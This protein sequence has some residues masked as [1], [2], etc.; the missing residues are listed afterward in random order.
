MSATAASGLK[1]TVADVLGPF[2]KPGAP[3]R[4]NGSLTER[5][6]VD[7]SNGQPTRLTIAGKVQDEDGNA[8][9]GA[10]LDVWQAGPPDERGLGS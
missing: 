8:M 4:A 6:G 3:V 5:P 2:Y 10:T 9:P 7:P 1:P